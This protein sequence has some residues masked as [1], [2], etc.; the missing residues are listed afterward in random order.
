MQY[1]PYLLA[2]ISVGG[3]YALIA[4]GYTMVYGILRLINFAHGDIFMAAG[5]MMIYLSSVMSIWLAMPIVIVLT[6]ILGFAVERV[7]YKPLRNA[8]RMSVMISAIGVS[9]L[10]QNFALYVTGGLA[11]TYPTLPWISD[12]ITILGATTKRVTVITPILTVVL[13]VGLV[14]LIKKT[15][16]GMAMRAVSRDFETSRLMGVKINTVIS[17]TFLL[18]SLLAAIGSLLYFA[19]YTAIVPTSGAMPGLKAFVAAVFGGIGSIPGAVIGA[20]LIGL[21]ENILKSGGSSWTTFS[22]AFTFVLLII[23]LAVKPTGLF[24]EKQTDK[25]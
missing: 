20:F 22:D 11:K 25:V 9:Y 18:G 10:I 5:L 21:S 14:I 13:I 19:N 23:V 7:A 4:I 24:G 12:S 3:Q 2:G 1:I 6:A 8:P 17:V 15:K 16:I